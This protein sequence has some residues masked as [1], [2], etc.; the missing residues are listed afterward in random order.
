MRLQIKTLKSE[1]YAIEIQD[2]ETVKDIKDKIEAELDLGAA[3]M[4]N[5]IHHGKVLRNERK[6]YEIEFVENDFV[7]LMLKKTRKKGNGSF[8]E[9]RRACEPQ[10]PEQGLAEPRQAEPRQASE[11]LSTSVNIRNTERN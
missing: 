6:V 8:S 10:G 1:K 3:D 11:L 7:V 5:L 4:M 2:N 9:P